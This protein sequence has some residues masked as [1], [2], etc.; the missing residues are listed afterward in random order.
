VVTLV[1]FLI[2]VAIDRALDLFNHGRINQPYYVFNMHMIILVYFYSVMQLSVF[3]PSNDIGS[4]I[5]YF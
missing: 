3:V 4:L 1:V 2:P 5:L